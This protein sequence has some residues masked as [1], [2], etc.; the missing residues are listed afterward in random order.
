MPSAIQ[1]GKKVLL[2]ILR[3]YPSQID[4]PRNSL[5]ARY[6]GTPAGFAKTVL[7]KNPPLFSKIDHVQQVQHKLKRSNG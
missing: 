4:P 3:S 1:T 6:I 2:S 5:P 7:L